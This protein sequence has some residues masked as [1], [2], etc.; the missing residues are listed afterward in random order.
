MSFRGYAFKNAKV[1]I[2]D[3]KKTAFYASNIYI[4]VGIHVDRYI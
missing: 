1:A 4:S 2:V 3:I